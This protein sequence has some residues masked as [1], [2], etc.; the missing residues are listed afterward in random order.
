M[1]VCPGG[2]EYDVLFSGDLGSIPNQD[3]NWH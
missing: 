2:L 1:C 3:P